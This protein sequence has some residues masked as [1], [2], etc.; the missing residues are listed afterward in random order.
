MIDPQNIIHRHKVAESLRLNMCSIWRDVAAHA[1]PLN[2]DIGIDSTAISAPSISGGVDIYDSTIQDAA[3][4]YSA[5]CLE[6]MTPHQTKW[7]A[8]SP[9][10]YLRDNDEAKSWYSTCT[11]I[12][13]ELLSATNF[14]SEIHRL[15]L[16]DGI[17][18][19][20]VM[21]MREDSQSGLHFD[22]LETGRFSI[23]E[24]ARRNVDK[25]FSVFRY[26]A[27]QA[28][29]EFGENAISQECRD[30]LKDPH[31]RD[32]EDW[33]FLHYIGPR[34]QRDRFKKN[35]QNAPIASV[36]IDIKEKRTVKESGFIS[37]PFAAHRHLPF[38][39]CPYGKSPGM[40][41]IFDARQLN[42]MQMQL[43]S[44]VEKQ[45]TPPV[46]AP[47]G[48]EGVIDLGAGGLTMTPDM[49][50]RPEYFGNPGN[51]LIGEDR[52]E[53]RKRQ[54]NT[55]FHVE[56][57]QALASVPVGKM[58]TAEEVRQ[59][60]N[61]RLPTFSPTF[62]R[63]N[64]EVNDPVMRM[65]FDTLLRREAFPPPPENIVR[66]L[67]D[68]SAYIPDPQI[69]YSSRMAQALQ[70]V[71]NDAFLETMG[72]AGQMAAFRPEV[73]DNFDFDDGVRTFARNLG[74]LESHIVPEAQRDQVRQQRA[75]QQAAE[76]EQAAQLEEGE[77]A[78]KLLPAMRQA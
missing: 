77:T 40:K 68:G 2:R 52:T 28:A 39:R 57:F 47:A 69:V 18:G 73:L 33:E 67:Q 3:D 44:L 76:M 66:M 21:M 15:Y 61:D 75:E 64:R 42:Y 35:I 32:K 11:D 41:A 22:C 43:D 62:A 30:A 74:V 48:F 4:V 14:Y 23:L 54:I 59:R 56:L 24:D 25:L 51:Y 29:K 63:K 38:G 8:F 19:T 72:V 26:S 78:A 1:D 36:W 34:E 16:L 58:M 45:V 49:Q 10:Y 65:I 31:K 6:W 7:F 50:N 27:V 46:V 70:Q 60:R 37:Q 5:G 13:F 12:A 53:F 20:T 55:A 9:P 71:H 17:Y